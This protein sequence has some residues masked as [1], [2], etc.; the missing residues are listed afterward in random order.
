LVRIRNI[1]SFNGVNYFH[2][3]FTISRRSGFA[4]VLTLAVLAL[5]GVLMLSLLV[6]AS[7]DQKSA[8]SHLSMITAKNAAA[9]GVNL[10]MAQLHS[11]EQREGIISTQPGMARVQLDDQTSVSY[12]LYS[13]QTM[14]AENVIP[15]ESLAQEIP[16]DWDERPDEFVDL[17]R[18]I[19]VVGKKKF[20]IFDPT[21][22]PEVEGFENRA[23]A[24]GYATDSASLPMPVRWLYLLKNG[25]VVAME[26]KIIAGASE[27]NPPIA[28]VGFW[29][30]DECCKINLNT[31]GSG[32]YWD[33][34]RGRGNDFEMG[35]FSAGS[36]T[37]PLV[38]RTGLAASIPG[39]REYQRYPGHPAMVS[40]DPVFF[41]HGWFPITTS[42]HDRQKRLLEWLPRL[43]YGGSKY[44]T[45]FPMQEHVAL[46]A[47][48][49]FA[50]VEE[51]LLAP[52]PDET[53]KRV[54]NKAD[55][56]IS[57]TNLNKAMSFLTTFS[58]APE[59]TAFGTPKVSI[60]PIDIN[61]GNRTPY[62][63][64][65]A[66]CSTS[67]GREYLFTRHGFR[68]DLLGGHARWPMQPW[69]ITG[70]H[71]QGA[72]NPTME[73]TGNNRVIMEYLSRLTKRTLPGFDGSLDDKFASDTNQMLAQIFD[74]VR[75]TNLYDLSAPNSRP[76]TARPWYWNEASRWGGSNTGYLLGAFPRPVDPQKIGLPL[77]Y[78]NF[79]PFVGNVT[80]ASFELDGESVR[81]LGRGPVIT[82]ATLV[83]VATEPRDLADLGLKTSQPQDYAR[84]ANF[85]AA[86]NAPPP[87]VSRPAGKI[88]AILIFSAAVPANGSLMTSHH[89][90]LTVKGLDQL[91]V[92]PGVNLGFPSTVTHNVAFRERANDT[93]K[94]SQVYWA[95][96]LGTNLISPV[97][98]PVPADA[99]AI[100][101]SGAQLTMEMTV[102]GAETIPIQTIEM[103]FPSFTAPL[104]NWTTLCKTRSGTN[105]FMENLPWRITWTTEENDAYGYAVPY[106]TRYLPLVP[107]TIDGTDVARGIEIVDG[108]TR[109][110][111][112]M[113]RVP[114]SRFQPCLHYENSTVFQAHNLLRHPRGNFGKLL[115]G[116]N[117]GFT[118]GLIDAEM[119]IPSRVNGARRAD[120]EP[121]DWD[122]G[123]PALDVYNQGTVYAGAGINKADDCGYAFRSQYTNGVAVPWF[124]T[125]GSTVIEQNAFTPNR[126]IPSPVM[127]G[128]L[129][130]GVKRE[131]PWQTLC[132]RPNMPAHP[133]AAN[134]PDYLWL[135]LFWMPQVEPYPL[136]DSFSTSGKINLNYQIAPFTYIHRATAL[137]GLLAPE[138]IIATPKANAL[139][140]SILPDG[141]NLSGGDAKWNYRYPV[142]AKA[143]VKLIE[144]RLNRG[145]NF[146]LSAEVCDLPLVPKSES[147]AGGGLKPRSYTPDSPGITVSASETSILTALQ[148]FWDRNPTADN[149]RERPYASLQPRVTTV[150]NSFT[151]H[152]IAQSIQKARSSPVGT[153]DET[154]DGIKAEWRGSSQIERFIDPSDSSLP[155]AAVDTD[156]D[157]SLH[158]R[159]RIVS[160]RRFAP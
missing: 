5:L 17:N 11:A 85:L 55:T 134:P 18:P 117:P 9:T 119:A 123:F 28:R 54:R 71:Q 24:A 64:T 80:P 10:V 50:S 31:A 60:W 91:E 22:A 86:K 58:R 48:R 15:S 137:H 30:D 38:T 88:Q 138:K 140:N 4:L 149:M 157:L 66:F 40:L 41:H 115:P 16:M 76:Y 97:R 56:E 37:L 47:D 21:S 78:Y 69:K 59:L 20:P 127:F 109:L 96:H 116:T 131:L 154:K 27:E 145:Q 34:P 114:A 33:T 63:H 148:Q 43:A 101:C 126:M 44:G 12:K 81:G 19:I 95:Y 2:A 102:G 142:D 100:Q 150:S 110:N 89:Y 84:P 46:D 42:T 105:F 111:A 153:F 135:D 72:L 155:D 51:L 68:D 73:T 70:A 94:I 124:R 147:D 99:T 90:N 26:N 7:L 151:V 1:T 107:L 129:P 136:S 125:N 141:S 130:A 67:A 98:V 49:L 146:R 13:A 3:K 36:N 65:L 152:Y 6:S 160:E 52:N 23:V 143:T 29:T 74:Y 32:L 108:D 121:G 75:M 128:S 133:G 112:A 77:A 57:P 83:F 159:W 79:A 113:S 8:G 158:Y 122:I 35:A 104:P 120:G 39:V 92:F 132:F 82:G 61:A 144:G 156:A 106:G 118:D 93:A 14:R 25:Q 62:D 87:L 139:W 53:G 103:N 45:A